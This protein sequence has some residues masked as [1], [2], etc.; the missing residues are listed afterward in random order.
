MVIG[1]R[2]WG[3]GS[4]QN[5]IELEG[6]KSALKLT[7]ASYHRPSG[8]NIHRFPDAKESDEWGV[9]PDAG[10]ELKLNLNQTERLIH[11]RHDR[12]ILLGKHAKA[13]A[14]KE[15]ASTAPGVEPAKPDAPKPEAA[16]PDA[17]KPDDPKPDSPKPDAPKPDEP[18]V[19][20]P[21][22]GEAKVAKTAFV[23]VQLQ[24]AIDYL[25]QELARAQ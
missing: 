2:T 9:M 15:Q 3:K 23:D 25:T 20:P 6:G 7:T 17:P 18:K 16:K 19:T 12:D 1:E 8:K 14:S 24:K 22:E 10:F 21:A 4:V 11:Y 5:V 13:A